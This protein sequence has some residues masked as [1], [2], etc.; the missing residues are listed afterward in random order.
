VYAISQ[1]GEGLSQL[2]AVKRGCF[3][4]RAP[5][6]QR[7]RR[8]HIWGGCLKWLLPFTV[9]PAPAREAAFLR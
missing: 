2:G 8:Y 1:E 6:S 3:L 9:T 5:C 4:L 7:H